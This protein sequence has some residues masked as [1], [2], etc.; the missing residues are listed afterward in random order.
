[1]C[2]FLRRLGRAVFSFGL[3]GGGLLVV[4]VTLLLLHL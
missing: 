1:M 4:V 2:A 3:G